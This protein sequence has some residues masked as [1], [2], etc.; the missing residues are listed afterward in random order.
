[1]DM[2]MSGL[3]RGGDDVS[4]ADGL[5]NY[6]M[7]PDEMTMKMHMF[8]LMYA[9]NNDVTLMAMVNYLSNDMDS[10]MKMLPG[11][12]NSGMNNMSMM[13]MRFSTQ[14]SG[15]DDTKL[16]AMIRGFNDG[17]SSLHYNIGVQLPTGQINEK[18]TTPMGS[19]VQLGYPMQTGTGSYH[20]LAGVTYW[21]VED[22]WRYGFQANLNI[23]IDDN[24]ANYKVGSGVQVQGWT[25]YRL[26]Q[27]LSASLRLSYKDKGQ[28]SG[29]NAD[30]NPM[31]MP[32]A[33]S[34]QTG[35]QLSEVALGFNYVF[36]GSMFNGHRVALEW[37]EP[38]KHKTDGLQMKLD[39]SLV[40]AWQ[41]A[42]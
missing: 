4:Q 24:S 31:M 29:Q 32:T 8:G 19:N 38:I 37:A 36:N 18:D 35:G 11:G 5:N 20:L 42:F 15:L 34:L 6:M 30:L 41:Y 28:T 2:Q 9:P 10:L 21:Q 12:M 25:S 27:D 26:H 22:K 13:P 23:P 40:F 14:S 1:M 16:Q 33:D 39:S 3:R 7:V 17:K